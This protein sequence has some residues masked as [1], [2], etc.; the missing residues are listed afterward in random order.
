VPTLDLRGQIFPEHSHVYAI[1][2]ANVRRNVSLSS[3][4]TTPRPKQHQAGKLGCCQLWK[5]ATVVN[6]SESEASVTF[7]AVPA[8]VSDLEAL[9][10][11][12]LQGIPSV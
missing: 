8:Q 7:D 12:R 6:P 4:F 5:S 1:R 3:V 11:H 9:A 10:G 2:C